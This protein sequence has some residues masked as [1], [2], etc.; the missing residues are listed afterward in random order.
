MN[1]ALDW[2]AAIL[3]LL[4]ALFALTAAIGLVRFPDTV[5]RMHPSTKTQVL[6]LILVLVGAGIRLR[7]SVDV[8]M[9]V[10]AG[11]FTV[12]VS[13]VF[14]HLVGRSAYRERG[15]RVDLMT[16]D[17]MPAEPEVVDESLDEGE[18]E[19][20]S[21]DADLDSDADGPGNPH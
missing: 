9:L 1:A 17:E 16:R 5:S 13:P 14:A 19:D 7:G 11:L 6:G 15:L 21:D 8:G 10:L 4:G 20:D 3:V 12:I 2:T 18:D